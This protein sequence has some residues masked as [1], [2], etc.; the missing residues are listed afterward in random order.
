MRLFALFNLLPL[1]ANDCQPRNV[2]SI[3]EWFV[4]LMFHAAVGVVDACRPYFFARLFE[5]LNDVGAIHSLG[6]IFKKIPELVPKRR[7][8]VAAHFGFSFSLFCHGRPSSRV[9]ATRAPQ[10]YPRLLRSGTSSPRAVARS[11]WWSCSWIRICRIC[12]AMANSPRVSHCRT[13]SR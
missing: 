5:R 11:I 8:R 6:L 13:L 3:A 4:I 1:Y 2:E 9:N 7:D 12:S 10:A